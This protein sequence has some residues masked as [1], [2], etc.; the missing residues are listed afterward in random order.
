MPRRHVGAAWSETAAL[1]ALLRSGRRSPPHYSDLVEEAGS[2]QVILEEEQG[3][4]AAELSAA[5]LAD[6]HNWNAQGLRMAT[7]L[8]PDYPANLRTVHDRPPLLFLA[9]SLQPGDARSVAVIGSRR[10]SSEGLERAG[11]IAQTL[12]ESRFTIVSGLAAGIDAAAHTTALDRGARTVAVIGT[13]LQHSYPPEN[14]CLQRRIADEGAVVSQFWPEA[15][16]SREA[17]PARNA[18]MS[19]LSLATVIVEATRTSGARI[20]ARHALAH[21]RPVLLFSSLLDQAW[22]RQLAERPGAHVITS[23]AEAVEIVD[24]FTSIEAPVA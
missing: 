4:L 19:G 7:V 11:V 16:P 6:L 10:A 20:Q 17:F 23:A 21:G 18:V 22:A 15:R 8:D 14:A 12:I 13:G 5:A 2:A 24:R 9:G 1:V 3:L